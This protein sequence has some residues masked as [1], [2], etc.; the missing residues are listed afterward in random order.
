DLG[1]PGDGAR[2]ALK[3]TTSKTMIPRIPG[4]WN[5]WH[6]LPGYSDNA[7]QYDAANLR[8]FYF[9]RGYFDALVR[10]N[11][12]NLNNPKTTVRYDIQAGPRY[13][14]REF[15]LLGVSGERTIAPRTGGVFPVRDA[16]NAL[17]DERREAERAGILDF[18]ARIEVRDL[19]ERNWATLHAT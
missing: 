1:A 18:S 5:G 14:I 2:K 8:S 6:I 11:T 7:V 19:P 4:I 3:W 13:T 16:C 15:R 17:L 12:V 10:A 9:E